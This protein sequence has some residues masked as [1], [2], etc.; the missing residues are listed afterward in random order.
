MKI[1]YRQVSSPEKNN[2]LNKLI[3]KGIHTSSGFMEFKIKT[4]ELQSAIHNQPVKCQSN[5]HEHLPENSNYNS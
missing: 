4:N 2:N 1:S 5:T 3:Q